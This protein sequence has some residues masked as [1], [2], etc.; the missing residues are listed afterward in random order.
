MAGSFTE[1]LNEELL[2][3]DTY[4]PD[5]HYYKKQWAGIEQASSAI[6]SWDT[7]IDYE[8]LRYIGEKSVQTPDSF[9]SF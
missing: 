1:K 9:V 3:V 6:T 4:Q 8:L 7:G 2:K 5:K